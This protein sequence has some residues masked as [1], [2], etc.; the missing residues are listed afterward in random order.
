MIYSQID[1]R[2]VPISTLAENNLVS[3]GKFIILTPM[4]QANCDS[5]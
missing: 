1:R 5:Y 4:T 2:R 3:Y